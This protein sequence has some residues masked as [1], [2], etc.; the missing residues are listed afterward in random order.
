MNNVT[1]RAGQQRD[2]LTCGARCFSV[3]AKCIATPPITAA[4]GIGAVTGAI[5][6]AA[7]W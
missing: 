6:G 7:N 3:C 2:L 4:D 5:L 1:T